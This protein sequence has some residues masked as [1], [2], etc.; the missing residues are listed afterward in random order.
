M[1]LREGSCEV[2]LHPGGRRGSGRTL[3]L[4]GT[5]TDQVGTVSGFDPP[6]DVHR[7]TN[8][9]ARVG[10]SLHVYGTDI[11]RI[12]NSVRHTYDLPIVEPNEID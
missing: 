10:V 8:S 3:L 7:V 9:G 11:G 2:D 6:G 12:G 5:R 4:T 1:T